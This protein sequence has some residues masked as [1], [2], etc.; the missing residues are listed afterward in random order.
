MLSILGKAFRNRS[1][2]GQLSQ[3]LILVRMWRYFS[4]IREN[5]ARCHTGAVT[6]KCAALWQGRVALL[7]I[8]ADKLELGGCR[9]LLRDRAG[10]V[11]EEIIVE[12]FGTRPV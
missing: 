4:T 11:F 7:E 5:H 8:R 9:P 6:S 12:I 1:I 3:R 10:S 2:V